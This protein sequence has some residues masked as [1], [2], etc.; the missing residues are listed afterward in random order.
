MRVRASQFS[1]VRGHLRLKRELR[2]SVLKRESHALVPPSSGCESRILQEKCEPHI[3]AQLQIGRGSH[4]FE[5]K[6]G[7]HIL[8]LRHTLDEYKSRVMPEKRGSDSLI[9]C[10]W[11]IL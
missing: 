4:A 5:M 11:H 2:I 8:A 3:L 7:P 1:T 9:Q 10:Q 6:C